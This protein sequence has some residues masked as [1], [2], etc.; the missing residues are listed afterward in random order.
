MINSITQMSLIYNLILSI[1]F[2]FENDRYIVNIASSNQRTTVDLE[3][4]EEER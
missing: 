2:Q 4:C 1:V 3:R